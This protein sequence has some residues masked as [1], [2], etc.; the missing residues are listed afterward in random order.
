LLIVSKALIRRTT[1]MAISDQESLLLSSLQV[2]SNN[3]IG[4][5]WAG[6]T[7]QWDATSNQS[8]EARELSLT[9]R[10]QLAETTKQFKRSVKNVEQA[11]SSLGSSNTEENATATVK[12]IEVLAKN[13]RLTVKSYQGKC[14]ICFAYNISYSLYFNPGVFAQRKSIT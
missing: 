13:C 1:A 14:L 3:W 11:G 2:A 8:K 6:K 9:A 5:D 4:F 10:K 7:K 12:A